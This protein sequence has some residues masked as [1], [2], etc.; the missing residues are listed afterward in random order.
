M[1]GPKADSQGGHIQEY[2]CENGLIQTEA[3]IQQKTPIKT[4]NRRDRYWRD[5]FFEFQ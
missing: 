1:D 5:G 2:L 4:Y 3:K